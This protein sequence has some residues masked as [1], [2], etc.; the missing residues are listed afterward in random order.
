MK[1]R[2]ELIFILL[3]IFLISFSSA[4]S[5]EKNPVSNVIIPEI[6][7]PAHF[8]LTITQA[9]LGSYNI[10]TLTDVRLEPATPFALNEGLNKIDVYVYPTEQLKERGFYS[11]T[12]TLNRDT[13]ESYNDKLTV[14]VVD[15]KDAI[16][17]NSDSNNPETGQIKFYIRNNEKASIKNL[18]A[19]F[20]SILF[21][22]EREFDLDEYEKKEIIVNVD[23][24]E[25]QKTKAGSYII[26][27]EF[28]TPKGKSAVDGKFF[29]GEKKEIKTQQDSSGFLIYTKTINKINTGNVPEVV[30]VFIKKDIFS[31]LFTSFNQEPISVE[32]SGFNVEYLWNKRLEPAEVFT[33]K[34]R[35]NYIFPLLIVVFAGILIIGFKRYTQTRIEAKKSVSHVKTKGGE[36]ALKIKLTIKAKKNVQNVSLID[37]VPPVV[38]VYEKF[39]TVK[40]DKIDAANRRIRWDI[41]D[42]NAGEERIFSYIVYSKI[43]VVGK[44]S[45]PEALVVFEK[46][47]EIHEIESNKVFFLSEQVKKD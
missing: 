30:E 29:I 35:T 43:G 26:K 2:R 44:F 15:L 41:G 10:Y 37:K 12:F 23:E 5:I 13:E 9:S 32:R 4:L 19:K 47:N 18:K 21:D 31:R 34:T 11:F 3:M 45:L 8:E 38:K 14:K 46:N 7:H 33:V 6:N 25:L 17:I 16:E 20:S 42:L 1:I 36:F 22:F 24:D 39:E 40:P 27:A 28:E